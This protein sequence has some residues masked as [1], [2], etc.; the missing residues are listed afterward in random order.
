MLTER[1]A[2]TFRRVEVGHHAWWLSTGLP[3]FWCSF[4]N[5]GQHRN[6]REAKSEVKCVRESVADMAPICFAD[7]KTL[8]CKI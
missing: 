2:F 3:T 7:M 8:G 6:S 5:Y 1:C 4:L